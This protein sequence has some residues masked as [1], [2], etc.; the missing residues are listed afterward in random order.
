MNL[1]LVSVIMNL[2]ELSPQGGAEFRYE[3]DQV[4]PVGIPME[5]WIACGRPVQV[6][7]RIEGIVNAVLGGDDDGTD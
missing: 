4:R 2:T 7:V 3:G 5:G 6:R 1:P